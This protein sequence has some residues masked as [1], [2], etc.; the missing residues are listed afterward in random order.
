VPNLEIIRLQNDIRFTQTKL[1][2]NE[3]TKAS[4]VAEQ[5]TSLSQTQ[6]F[7][8]LASEFSNAVASAQREI[9]AEE[10][11]IKLEANAEARR[12]TEAVEAAKRVEAV[13]AA[14]RAA[15]AETAKQAAPVDVAA[16]STQPHLTPPEP[17][18]MEALLTKYW[19][20]GAIVFL[21]GIVWFVKR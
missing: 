2:E 1:A 19:Y 11:R 16:Q 12:I 14:K 3:A 10:N 6:K 18:T 4:L 13:E 20:W 21:V 5:N 15:L 8:A 7:N 9:A 17:E